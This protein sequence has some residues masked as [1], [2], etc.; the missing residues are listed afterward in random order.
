MFQA[1]IANP[2]S[3]TDDASLSIAP[4]VSSTRRW[5]LKSASTDGSISFATDR[6]LEK[7][8]AISATTAMHT[9]SLT[10]LSPRPEAPQASRMSTPF[11]TIRSQISARSFYFPFNKLCRPFI[12]LHP[13]PCYPVKRG[14]QMA[15]ATQAPATPTTDPVERWL[16]RRSAC[17]QPDTN[18]LHSKMIGSPACVA[19]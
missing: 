17:P 16:A 8:R 19:G 18:Q 11:P 2:A 7:M 6:D 1:D 4:L 13:R 3:F 14:E 10:S 5:S 12:R 15:T 9:V